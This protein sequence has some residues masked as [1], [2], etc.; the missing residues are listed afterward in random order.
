MSVQ[1][2]FFIT[3]QVR[4]ASRVMEFKEIYAYI[5]QNAVQF[6]SDVLNTSSTIYLQISKIPILAEFLLKL[7]SFLWIWFSD[8]H[9]LTNMLK[10][11]NCFGRF[12]FSLAL[13]KKNPDFCAM[14]YVNNTYRLFSLL[15][16]IKVIPQNAILFLWKFVMKGIHVC[17]IGN[18]KYT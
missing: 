10:I 1:K 15:T 12:S 3:M 11:L 6:L 9:V 13:S 16:S 2:W 5:L 4:K 7:R 8:A 18:I 17:E 14:L